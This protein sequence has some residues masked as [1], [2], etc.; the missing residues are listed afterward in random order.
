MIPAACILCGDPVDET[1]ERLWK[2]HYAH[3]R[4]LDGESAKANARQEVLA[5]LA[6]LQYGVLQVK[7][8]G[9][10]PIHVQGQE[11]RT[12]KRIG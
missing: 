1:C 7:V 11:Y 10:K 9:G 6:E 4:C 12:K 5:A 3:E 8:Q 2:H